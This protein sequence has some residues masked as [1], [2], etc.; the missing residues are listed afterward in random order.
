MSDGLCVV[1]DEGAGMV[2][3]VLDP[4]PEENILDC[5]AAP[6]GKALFAATRLG[7]QVWEELSTKQGVSHLIH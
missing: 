2:V 5:C 3:Q 4:Q 6:G 1:Q 7:G